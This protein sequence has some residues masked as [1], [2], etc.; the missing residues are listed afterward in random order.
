MSG[1][2]TI[3]S[4]PPPEQA[5]RFRALFKY[6]DGQ[7]MHLVETYHMAVLPWAR[8]TLIARF[9][10]TTRARGFEVVRESLLDSC[11]LAIAKLLLDGDDTNP[12][13]LTMLGPFR[14]RQQCSEVM[15]ILEYDNAASHI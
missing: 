15:Q 14:D 12:S 6:L 11:I 10:K 9:K 3:F 4:L 1:M 7:Y 2:E 5:E 8:Q 13:L